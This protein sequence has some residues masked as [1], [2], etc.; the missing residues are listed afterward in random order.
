[1]DRAVGAALGQAL[2]AEHALAELGLAGKGHEVLELLGGVAATFSCLSIRTVSVYT[3][4][5]LCRNVYGHG[6]RRTKTVFTLASTGR[7]IEPV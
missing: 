3:H 2:G 6:G 4:E 1:M 5:R 7:Q